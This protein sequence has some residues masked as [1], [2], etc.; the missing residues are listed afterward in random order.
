[1]PNLNHQTTG[2]GLAI[3]ASMSFKDHAVCKEGMPV[4][5]GSFQNLESVLYGVV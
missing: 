3:E 1:M 4:R 2:D 5:E